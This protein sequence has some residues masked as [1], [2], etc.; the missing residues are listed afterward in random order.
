MTNAKAGTELDS[1]YDKAAWRI[2][3]FLFI[4]FIVAFLDR[5]NIGFAQ[6]QMKGDIGFNDAVYG[7]GA[8]IFFLGYFAFEVPSNLLLNRIG[9]RLTFMRIMIC[10]GLVSAG[11]AFV[12]APWQ[13]YVM[14]FLLGAFEAGFFPG[15]IL[16]LTFWFPTERRAGVVSW[17]FVAV[18][19]A[20]VIGGVLS[21]TIMTYFAGFGGL[22]GWQWMFILEG[23]PAVF[24]GVLAFF[25]VD[26]GPRSAKWL[27]D[28][29]KSLLMTALAE[30]E[31]R[32]QN[33]VSHSLKDAFKS[34]KVYILAAVYFM[35]VCGTMAI[36]FWL[37]ALIKGVSSSS[38][39]EVGMLSSIP[40]GIGAIAI[41]LISK[42]S[43]ARGER[44]T[45]YLFCA[46][47]GALSLLALPSAAGHLVAVVCL[48]CVAVGLTFS[49][50][51]IFWS[52]PQNYLSGRAAV[53]GIALISSLG[54]LGSFFSPAII[55][56]VKH[57]TGQLDSGLYALGALLLIS[58][59]TMFIAIA[60]RATSTQSTDEKTVSA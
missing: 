55:G 60:P 20:G 58:G 26:D 57:T 13:L 22:S 40:Y 2:L 41:V 12:T 3:P 45:H 27:T 1:I 33:D 46:V 11:M 24:L 35:L 34:P 39:L 19:L 17:I 37:P 53:G 36:A 25:V 51:P 4:S 52:V 18:A 44:R 23:L 29:E 31:S 47:G 32:N 42:S 7:L 5:I 8:G 56:W 50:L 49:A 14:R 28:R 9:A 59:L 54:Q 43:D 15:I 21:G 10:W 6:L 48:L 30:D 16:Y 38:V